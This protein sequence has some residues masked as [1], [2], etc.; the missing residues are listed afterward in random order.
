MRARSDAEAAGVGDRV[1]FETLDVSRGLPD[2]FDVIFTF[3]VV[4]GAVHP[5]GLLRAIRRALRPEGIYVCLDINCSDKLEE[6]HGPLGTLFH[7]FSVLY[8]LTTSLAGGGEGLGTLGLHE[9][10]LRELCSEAD[11]AG[12]RRVDI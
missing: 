6:N 1:R 3:D 11:F 4:H 7:G 12:V 10:M 9:P 2:S 8:C 5:R